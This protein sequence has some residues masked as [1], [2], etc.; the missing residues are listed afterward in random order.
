MKIQTR[1]LMYQV[2]DSHNT[3]RLQE[4]SVTI[5]PI[6]QVPES[7][8]LPMS[9]KV[10]LENALRQGSETDVE[11]I[12][13]AGCNKTRGTDI[14]FMPAR[15]LLTDF[16]GVPCMVDLAAMR[17][18]VRA[19]G[20]DASI[21]NPLIPTDLVIDHSV[22][23][24]AAC[25]QDAAQI[26]LTKDYE[27][28]EERYA[29]LKWA[30]ES[31]D[32]LSIVPPGGGICHQ[33]NIEKLA[34]GVMV[35][36]NG[37][38][39][40]DTLV[41]ADSHTTTVN[42]IG[43]LGWGVGG[44][45]AEA[46]MLGQKI[47]IL[48]PQVLG[49]KLTGELRPGVGAMDLALTFARMLR[50]YGVVGKLVEC[51]GPGC[52]S[53]TATD[54]ATIANMSPEYGCTATLFGVDENTL[55][56][57]RQTNRDENQIALIKAYAQAQGLWQDADTPQASY[58]DVI[59]LD[60]S[61]V[62]P[63]VAGPS[64]PHD[65]IK[66][67]ELAQSF[68][69]RT[70]DEDGKLAGC[71]VALESQDAPV[72]LADGAVAIAAITSCTT[73]ANPELMIRAGLV[74]KHAVERGLEAKPWIKRMLSPGSRSGEY[75]LE[76][77]GL[78][79]PLGKLGFYLSGFGCM[80][81]IGNSGP[82]PQAMQEAGKQIELAAVLSGNRNFEG[83]IGPDIKQNYL[84]APERVVAYA[85]AGSVAVDLST[86]PLG[87]ATDGRPVFLSELLPSDE[88]VQAHIDQALGDPQ[89]RDNIYAR[90]H[91]TLF[92]GDAR[93]RELV[94][95]KQLN[96]NWDPTSTYVQK[97]PY[98]TSIEAGADRHGDTAKRG[99][100]SLNQAICLGRFGDFVTTDH[101]SPAGSIAHN[102]PAADYLR[103]H[104]VKEADFNTYGSRR[105]N[106]EVMMRGT[107]ANIRLQNLMTNKASETLPQGGWT[108]DL[109]DDTTKT[110]W[111]ASSAYREAGY[112]LIIVAG[113]LYGSGSSRDW[114]AK[115]PALIGVRAVLC[116]SF[117][118]IHRSNLVG[119]GILPLEFL[120][121]ESAQTYELDGTESYALSPHDVLASD[122]PQQVTL[123]VTRASGETF[124]IPVCLRIDTPI[125]AQYI[126]AGGILPYVLHEFER[127]QA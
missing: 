66:A 93:W 4:N 94:A 83:R 6:D 42:G 34:H 78:L 101:I 1:I 120:P 62:E 74:A 125:E 114:A 113:K 33:L 82:L 14:G 95:V 121:G 27:R 21:I 8:M 80:S 86:E 115:G 72:T 84:M 111:E 96:Y 26:N 18:A 87:I 10:L 43:V 47:S 107:F 22:I 59:E 90:A 35:D 106:H 32:N 71:E 88:E 116:E 50:D 104:G 75:L 79:E 81:C 110:I 29:F 70:A 73:T 112:D 56:F 108:V 13:Q 127:Q 63:C 99:I 100:I 40:F 2:A 31:F 28:N 48:V 3:D 30:Q 68:F 53:L 126:A 77:A 103:A 11:R 12:V 98:F 17:D 19:T 89:S 124:E 52:A 65:Y 37:V 85:I 44:I 123:Q 45:E 46:A 58:S 38:A 117:E 9:L 64:R 20:G 5:Y 54:R 69:T 24:D 7:H 92:E 57:Y 67:S 39:Y 118:R 41:G 16:T 15:V 76:R 109:L 119:M 105:G 102:V 61:E 91:T 49:I 55:A 36:K 23:G 97:P 25:C 51:F 60:L 122:Y